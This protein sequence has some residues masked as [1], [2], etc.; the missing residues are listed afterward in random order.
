MR[1][2]HHFLNRP[3]ALL[4]SEVMRVRAF[5]DD[6]GPMQPPA[7]KVPADYSIAGGIAVIPIIGALTHGAGWCWHDE[8]SYSDIRRQFAHALGNDQVRASAYSAAYAL[9]SAADHVTVPR[10]GGT[11]S[12][13]VVQLHADISGML[14]QAGIKITTITFGARKADGSPTAPLKGAALERMQA[15]VDALGELFVST[16]ARNRGMSRSIVRG[17]EAGTFLGA[18]GVAAGLADEVA[19]PDH[20]FLSLVASLPKPAAAKPAAMRASR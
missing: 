18:A 17:M 10:T 9:A 15:S 1:A 8:T 2:A 3:L 4:Q 7:R 19:S 13:G 20:A 11:G 14:D 12:I 6:D 16:V 5:I